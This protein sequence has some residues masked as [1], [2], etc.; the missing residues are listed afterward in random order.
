MPTL[1]DLRLRLRSIQTTGHL[2]AAMR[3]SST[4]KLSKVNRS[5]TSFRPYAESCLALRN[6]H[7][8]ALN[9]AFP[10]KDPTAPPCFVVF[11]SNRGLCG[12]YNSELLSFAAS[13]LAE[14]PENRI[15]FTCGKKARTFF[16]ERMPG[17]FEDIPFPDVPSHEDAQAL[18]ER[19]SAGYR[20]GQW[21]SV[22]FLY[23]SYKNVLTQ[24]PAELRLL[25][26]APAENAAAAEESP[27]L[28]P[29]AGTV[30]R[31]ISE[32]CFHTLVYSTVL[33][34]AAG[35]QAATMM[36]MRTAYDNA[37][38]MSS[39]LELSINRRRQAEVTSGVIETSS[40]QKGEES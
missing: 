8:A 36:A 25:P 16:E 2:A 1:H 30:Y 17:T 5:L 6:R 35:A 20:N 38:D 34:A 32:K 7:A 22:T 21:S 13:R 4:A 15:L 31:E 19:L 3:T 27:L 26:P 37:E 10:A 9:N 18:A 23:Q 12:G 28:L 24:T 33:E 39:D 29:D 40:N 11:S 14:A